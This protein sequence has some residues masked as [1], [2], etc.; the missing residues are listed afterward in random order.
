MDSN[1][2]AMASP[3]RDSGFTL[4]ELL[5]SLTILTGVLAI[6]SSTLRTLSQHWN[7]NAN[8]LERIEMVAR[9]FDI[10]QRD[11]SGLQRLIVTNDNKQRFLFTGTPNRLSFVTIEP[12]YPTVPGPYFIDYSIAPNGPSVDLVRARAPYVTNMQAFPGATPANRVSLMQGPFKYQFS[13]ALKEKPDAAWT[14][15]WRQ[16]NKLPGVI[17]L[18]II[19]LANGG[20]ASQPFVAA[21]RTDAEISCIGEGSSECSPKTGGELTRIG[22]QSAAL[23]TAGR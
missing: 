23:G 6:L 7:A 1:A 3:R 14:P 22:D 20:Y 21:L 2:T 4:I 11:V 16:Q 13:Y 10:F 18:E 8:R 5:V 17:R 12:P 9:A 19:D 15:T